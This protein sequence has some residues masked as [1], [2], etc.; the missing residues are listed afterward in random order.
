MRSIGDV[1]ATML[2]AVDDLDWDAVSASFTAEIATD[3]TSLWGGEPQVLTVDQLISWWRQLAPG[4][5]TTQ[6]L[7]GPVVVTDA[8]EHSA[9]CTTNVRG[10]HHVD[11]ATWMVAGRYDMR[12]VRSGGSDWQIAAVTLHRYYED[13]DRDLADAA[14]KR[15]A[16][17][18]GRR[19][20]VPG[21]SR[22]ARPS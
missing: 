22:R 17:G 8:D 20:T 12:L 13:G 1:V 10:Y 11:G 6:H 16:E 18:T 3:Y 2:H 5:D 4:F 19:V 21:G 15:V 14:T 9:T 7:I